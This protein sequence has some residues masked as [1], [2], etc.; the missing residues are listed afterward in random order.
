MHMNVTPSDGHFKMKVPGGNQY[1][2]RD[3]PVV[4]APLFDR[5]RTRRL[6]TLSEEPRKESWHVLHN[7]DRQLKPGR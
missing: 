2:A 1:L 5:Q 3:H 4:L 7:Q 6:K